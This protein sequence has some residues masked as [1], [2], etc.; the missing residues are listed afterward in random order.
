MAWPIVLVLWVL[1]CQLL[2]LPRSIFAE[3][4]EFV[5]VH[6]EFKMSLNFK[7]DTL[8][9]T[10]VHNGVLARDVYI[11]KTTISF[12]VDLAPGAYFH[13]MSRGSGN[14]TVTAPDGILIDG[15]ECATKK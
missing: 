9:N 12:I 2:L 3:T 10:I 15:Y 7:I 6:R 13:Y 1:A 11:D 8:K 14:M 4:F 5:C